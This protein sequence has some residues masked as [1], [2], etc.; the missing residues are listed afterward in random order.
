MRCFSRFMFSGHPVGLA[1]SKAQTIIAQTCQWV[2]RLQSVE[3]A[4]RSE[5]YRE[6]MLKGP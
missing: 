4:L 2:H 5:P 3:L 1:V 6:P